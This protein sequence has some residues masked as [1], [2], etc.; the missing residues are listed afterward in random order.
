MA[1]PVCAGEPARVTIQLKWRHQFQFAGYYAAI[2]QGYFRDAG[3]D[4]TLREAR[5]GED[6][7]E[8]VASGGADYGIGTS[9]L[10]VSRARGAPLVALAATYQHSPFGI[11]SLRGHGIE[12]VHDLVGKRVMV[13]PQAAEIWAYLKLEGISADRLTL[14]PHSF[15]TH[16]LTAG[17]V[18]AMTVY[19]TDETF[20]LQQAGLDFQLFTARSDGIDFYSDV[21]FS[22]EREVRAHP[23]R[24][25]AV[26]AAVRKGW[27]YAVAHPD[28]MVKLI[29]ERYS[30]RKSVAELLYEAEH[31]RALMALDVVEFGYMSEGRWRHIADTYASL[32]MIDG[33]VSLDDFLY[34]PDIG[35][36]RDL[37]IR[38][39]IAMALAVLVVG[40]VGGRFYAL[41]RQLRREMAVRAGAEAGLTAALA[42]ER[43]LLSVLAHDFRTPLSVISA[44]AQLIGYCLSPDDGRGQREIGKIL[45]A[46]RKLSD[47]IASCLAKDRL[48][49]L[50]TK[51]FVPVDLTD[52]LQRITAEWRALAPNRRIYLDIADVETGRIERPVIL[53]D[54]SLLI[55][56]I[57]N[58]IDNALR[59]TPVEGRVIVA[60]SETGDGL[61]VT[62]SDDGP[63]IPEADR[64]RIFEKYYRSPGTPA[65]G[66]AG[67]GLSVVAGVV[68]AHG[69]SVRAEPG[70]CG[71]FVVT[72]PCLKGV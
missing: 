44:S 62:V 47:L 28:E 8:V 46:A 66:G 12:T 1:S 64:E 53:G 23:D 49:G 26:I 71:R 52:V 22:T 3:L 70:D 37:V 29:R 20:A 56:A 69:G 54:R 35:L 68:R 7:A 27:H 10:V 6:P 9:E 36:D 11:V 48:E 63:G 33:S 61:A 40:G 45:A 42:Q 32:G 50:E 4:V 17:D 39:S 2:D 15:D 24:V 16:S 43:N 67:I 57:S 38:L 19:T 21:L 72:L 51:S 25:P 65:T 13:E 58:L 18:D 34:K 14:V 5:E 31:G 41:S 55:V 59:Y 60:L 30:D